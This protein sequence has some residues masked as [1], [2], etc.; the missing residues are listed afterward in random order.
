MERMLRQPS[1]CFEQVSS[2]NYPNLLVL[3]L[4]RQ[5]GNAKP[6]VESRAMTL[7]ADGYKKL[8]AYECK[9]GG[10]DWW[11]RDPGHEGLTAYG[12]LEFTD[13]AKVFEVDKRMM[14]RTLNWMLS[15]RDGKGSW[16]RNQ[17]Q[18]GWQTDG[19]ID[20]YIAW[21]VAE[22]GY[23]KQFLTEIDHA[24]EKAINSNDPY[25]LA[26]MA[27]ALLAMNDPRGKI[28]LSMISDRQQEDGSWIG[29][30][31]SVMYAHGNCFRIETTAL[32]ALAIM[33]SGEK[34][35]G[36]QKAM[37]YL[38]K[39]KTEYGYGST[40]STVTAL[41]A[42]VEFVKFGNRNAAD[43]QL[44]VMVDGR[45]VVEQP[46]SNSDPKRIE[47]KNL[48]QYFTSDNPRME[49]FFENADAALPFDL[50]IKYASRQPRN[51]A[52]C[53]ISFQTTLEQNTARVGETVRLS[54]ALKN[55][56]R[57]AQASP[58]IVL[59]IPAGLTLQPWQL[60]KLVDEKQCD[61]YELW[62]GFAVFHFESLAPGETRKLA[63]DLRADVAG[64]F[65]APASQAFLYYSNDQR[66]WSK[67]ERLT[68]GQ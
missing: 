6:E 65:E 2:S 34:T 9:T 44:V 57:E 22:A 1:G 40:Q 5:T 48:E 21:A 50:E 28:M 17:D 61:F 46:Y 19:I 62:D 13:M 60:K 23:G 7:L 64:T 67:P 30:S 10:F 11:G 4:L 43:G 45:R 33:K 68:I 15:R 63:L 42:L 32:V 3:D 38:A 49:V 37:D 18:H 8:T 58:M 51:T 54:A 26:L 20:A 53:P 66:V 56:T 59:G 55:E 27:N 35:V 14:E 47:I 12:L 31:H 25:Q 29:T 39:S 16:K 24:R 52:N 41:K 36:L